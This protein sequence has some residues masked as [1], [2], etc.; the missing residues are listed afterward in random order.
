MISSAF[1]VAPL[2]AEVTGDPKSSS[3]LLISPISKTGSPVLPAPGFPNM[4]LCLM[5]GLSLFVVVPGGV[6]EPAGEILG[7][8]TTEEEAFLLE[9]ILTAGTNSDASGSKELLELRDEK[10]LRETLPPILLLLGVENVWGLDCDA[11]ESV[12]LTPEILSSDV[13]TKGSA[14]FGRKDIV[15][16][17]SSI[18]NEFHI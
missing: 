7:D 14:V 10:M 16:P 15:R 17:N 11:E 2:N 5:N 1:R 18:V 4:S 3:E 8:L 9:G 13:I 6:L 12:E